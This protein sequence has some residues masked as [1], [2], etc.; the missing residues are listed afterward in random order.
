MTVPFAQAQQLCRE[1]TQRPLHPQGFGIVPLSRTMSALHRGWTNSP[2][3]AEVFLQEIGIGTT[4][5][6]SGDHLVAG[7]ICSL[8]RANPPCILSA[9]VL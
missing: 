4:K 2:R 6:Q 1:I 5:C 3:T 8:R 9:D 7:W